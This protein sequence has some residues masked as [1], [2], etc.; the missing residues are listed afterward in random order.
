MLAFLTSIRVAV[1]ITPRRRNRQSVELV[2]TVLKISVECTKAEH[3]AGLKLHFNMLLVLDIC[4][5]PHDLD[6]GG[7]ALN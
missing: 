3:R 7:E 5:R 1:R 4:Q 2:F 6:L